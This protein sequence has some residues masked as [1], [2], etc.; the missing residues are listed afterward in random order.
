M[1]SPR[2]QRLFVIAALLA[3]SSLVW[4]EGGA[5]A[6]DESGGLSGFII[7]AIIFNI[8][9]AT[10]IL[11]LLRKEWNKHKAATRQ[12]LSDKCEDK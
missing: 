5:A 10:L 12:A 1:F 6:G 11:V 8:S 2:L 7:A 4:G 3:V 9:M